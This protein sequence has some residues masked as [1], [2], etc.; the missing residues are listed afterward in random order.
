MDDGLV[1]FGFLELVEVA[2]IELCVPG[3][4]V[5]IPAAKFGGWRD[6]FA[7]FVEVAVALGQSSRP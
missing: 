4:V 3:R 2:V 7:S 1:R 5:V 6:L